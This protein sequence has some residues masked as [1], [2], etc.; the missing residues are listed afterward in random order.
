MSRLRVAVPVDVRLICATHQRLRDLI[1]QRTF[2]DDLYYLLNG[3][4]ARVPPLRDRTDVREIIDRLLLTLGGKHGTLSP[5][6]LQYM[7]TH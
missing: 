6:V 2:R 7:L 5:Q 3:L 4:T 1:G